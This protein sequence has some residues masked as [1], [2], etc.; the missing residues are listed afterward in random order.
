FYEAGGI[1]YWNRLYQDILG[2]NVIAMPMGF[3]T[4]EFLA[5]SHVPLRETEDFV[6]LKY[7]TTGWWGEILRRM[8]V[9][10]TTLPGGEVYPALERRVLDATEFASPAA[11]RDLG[12]YE[13]TQYFT[14]PGM[15]QPTSAL[16]LTINRDAWNR[17]PD[18]LKAI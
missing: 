4:T 12:F 10:V 5:W 7:R 13:V 1:D 18:D 8:G 17:L 2:L 9:S 14:G 3:N 16:E 6:G 15:H 11:D